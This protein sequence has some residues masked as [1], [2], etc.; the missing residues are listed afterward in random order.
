MLAR[1]SRRLPGGPPVRLLRASAQQLPLPDRCVD[2]V[3]STLVFH[4]LPDPAKDAAVGELRR[5]LTVR[6]RFLLVDFGPP[7]DA[8]TGA[9]LRA[10]SLFDGRANMR[11]QLAG[12]LPDLLA[13]NGFSVRP[14]R[15]PG[16]AVH[17]L[18][19]ILP[20]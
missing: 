4:H 14:A 19:G 11:S 6:G 9:L 7:R 8:W 13:R 12:E 18:L 16:R 20:G 17:H 10:G 1:A 15:P 2:V 5:V 3:V